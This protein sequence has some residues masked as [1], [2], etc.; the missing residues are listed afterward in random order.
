MT[1]EAEKLKGGSLL[2]EIYKLMN[3]STDQQTLQIYSFL[4]NKSFV[5]YM[6]MLGK[7]IYQG[8]IDDIFEEFLI[9]EKKTIKKDNL[10]SKYKDDYWEMRFNLR[11]EQVFIIFFFL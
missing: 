4:L 8:L 6:D 7:W 2:S 1:E 3:S 5:P 11:E 9:S 10:D